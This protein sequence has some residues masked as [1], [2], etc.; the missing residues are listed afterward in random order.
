MQKSRH[1]CYNLHEMT[2]ENGKSI[3]LQEVSDTINNLLASDRQNDKLPARVLQ[4]TLM[5]SGKFIIRTLKGP[6]IDPNDP[7]RDRFIPT[8]I[9][10]AATL[11]YVNFNSQFIHFP[12]KGK[13]TY[14][15]EREAKGTITGNRILSIGICERQAPL[16]MKK[17]E[18]EG[19]RTLGMI[20]VGQT[21]RS[22]EDVIN[23]FYPA[24]TKKIS[25][26]NDRSDVAFGMAMFFLHSLL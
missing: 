21:L 13:N 19:L 15:S 2:Q 7:N 20:T 14:D 8:I 12:Q 11:D 17:L 25:P 26:S 9:G 24:V 23:V 5:T 6:Q 22:R 1:F 3:G 16:I 18:E 4:E 10:Y